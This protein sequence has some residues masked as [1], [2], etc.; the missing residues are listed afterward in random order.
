MYKG[1][2]RAIVKQVKY[3]DELKKPYYTIEVEKRDVHTFGEN[4]SA[5]STNGGA[6]AAATSTTVYEKGQT[7]M[8]KGKERAIVKQVEYDD[9]L[10]PYYT[11]EV[12]KRDVRTFGEHLSEFIEQEDTD[13]DMEDAAQEE[14]ASSTMNMEQVM[15]SLLSNSDFLKNLSESEDLRTLLE[16]IVR[17]LITNST[18]TVEQITVSLANNEAF[19]QQ[20]HAKLFKQFDQT[21]QNLS[22]QAETNNGEVANTL[23]ELQN[24]IKFINDRIG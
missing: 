15:S 16:G 3:D 9:E 17:S 4:L 11:I 22:N 10:K 8:Y 12:E 21:M 23:T 6:D 24:K 19:L 18:P 2:E 7:V 14:T 5:G 20:V 1:K 13:V